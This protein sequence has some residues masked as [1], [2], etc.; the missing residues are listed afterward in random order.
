MGLG[1]GVVGVLPGVALPVWAIGAHAKASIALVTLLAPGDVGVTPTAVLVPVGA[2][3][4]VPVDLAIGRSVPDGVP[5]TGRVVPT[6]VIVGV[7][8]RVT[9][10]PCV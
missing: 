8:G 9:A 10:C 5:A 1:T 4:G 2:A 3:I 6:T 7:P